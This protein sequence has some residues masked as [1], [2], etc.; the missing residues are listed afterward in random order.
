MPQCP[1]ADPTLPR[2]SIWVAFTLCSVATAI[3]AFE[4]VYHA[5]NQ[6]RSAESLY[7]STVPDAFTPMLTGTI[8]IVVQ[9]FLT[10]RASRLFNRQRMWRALFL[11]V[12]APVML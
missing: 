9:S 4:A 7:M 1:A 2:P 3:N 12:L 5:V 6:D 8:G 11:A 10:L